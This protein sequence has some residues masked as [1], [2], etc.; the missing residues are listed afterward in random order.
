VRGENEV[1]IAGAE[2]VPGD[3]LVLNEGDRVAADGILLESI[4]LQVD[5]SLLTGEAEAVE[6]S[7]NL[8]TNNGN[9]V[10]ASTLVTRGGGSA[11]VLTTGANTEVGK[12]GKTLNVVLTERT[13]L[14]VEI[15][16]LARLFT[17]IGILVSVGVTLSYVVTRGDWPQGVLAGI[18]AAMSLMPEEF[19]VIMTI[20]LALGAWRL[21]KK[22]VLVRQAAATE[23]LGAITILCV[24][25]TG[26]LT[27][28]QMSVAEC[29]TSA[30]LYKF[31]NNAAQKLP[32]SF[33]SL[34]EYGV[35]ASH[36]DP[37]DPMELAIKRTLDQ[38][39][40]G[41]EHIHDDWV[42]EREYPLTPKL[43]AMSCVWKSKSTQGFRIA[44][45]GAPEAIM[46]LCHLSDEHSQAILKQV[47]SMSDQGLRILAVAKA[48]FLSPPLPQIQHDF[49]F[50]FLGLIGMRD[51]IRS[52]VPAAIAE[53]QAAGIRVLMITGDYPGTAAKIA[54]DVGLSSPGLVL[55][56]SEVEALS[57]P[58]LLAKLKTTNVFAR[59]VPN[60]KLRLIKAL[61]SGGEVVAMTG[62]GVNDAPS[63]KWADVGIAMGGRGTDVARE[64]SDIVLL[65]DCFTSIVMAIRSGRKIFDNIKSAMSYV[66]AIHV[67]IA[68][69]AILPVLFGLPVAL[70]PA[71]IVFLELV[72]DPSCTLIFE[73]DPADEN[74]MR[75]PPRKLGVRLFSWIE[76]MESVIQ[77]LCLLLV[78]FGVYFV[79]HI[80]D[81]TPELNRTIAFS[82]FVFA[83]LG[84]I[85]INRPHVLQ[86]GNRAFL[87]VSVLAVATLNIVI[88]VPLLRPLF[89]FAPMSPFNWSVAVTSAL[90]ATLLGYVVRAGLK[91][92]VSADSR[93][94][95]MHELK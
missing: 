48:E 83:N 94:S 69:M 14:Q 80:F 46:D 15:G 2:V 86:L 5:E 49:E 25:K 8:T 55:S 27:L 35:L 43:L 45:K 58:D 51:P 56:G 4:N 28:N 81:H 50:S 39:L 41:T 67:P 90:A 76:I 29:R 37:F 36:R 31:E 9:K 24:D 63:L 34:I 75:R 57:E 42:L 64:A 60:Q 84:L 18:A 85:A 72:I 74:T 65:D 33:H 17:V 87:W 19:P 20:F 13:H 68:G 32:E 82:A 79:C 26:T 11:R 16:K 6:K 1:R 89:G 77:G 23:N 21:S 71:H 47:S 38:K 53:C 10:F 54:A 66:F 40:A 91:K 73:S 52:E 78:I 30:D 62:D 44:A 12:I 93:P 59:M 88:Y 95:G 92:I 3:V 61:K 22:N 7:A 70:F